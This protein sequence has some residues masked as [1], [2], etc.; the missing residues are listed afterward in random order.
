[1]TP[2]TCRR[3]AGSPVCRGQGLGSP[4]ADGSCWCTQAE[5]IHMELL[6]WG[7]GQ[8]PGDLASGMDK[9]ITTSKWGI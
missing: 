1:M 6:V 3:E 7:R 8:T 9:Q 4:L 2:K 5:L